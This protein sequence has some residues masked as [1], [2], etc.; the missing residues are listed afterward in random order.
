MFDLVTGVRVAAVAL[1]L[2]ELLLVLPRASRRSEALWFALF[3][4]ALAALSAVVGSRR[5]LRERRRP[6]AEGERHAVGGGYLSRRRR[7][8]CRP[9]V[10]A[11]AGGVAVAGWSSNLAMTGIAAVGG[12]LGLPD[13]PPVR[14]GALAQGGGR[15]LPVLHRRG[16]G[17]GGRLRRPGTSRRVASDPG[18]PLR[19]AGAGG[20][21]RLLPHR[22]RL[23]TDTPLVVGPPAPLPAARGAAAA[24][25]L[26]RGRAPHLAELDRQHRPPRSWSRPRLQEHAGAGEAG[27]RV[28]PQW[29]T[30]TWTRCA[31]CNSSCSR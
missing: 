30:T 13:A 14:S 18:H 6:A 4:G 17:G 1:L 31:P 7:R 24:P 27:R 12:T 23:P 29:P 16:A 8:P 15:P 2:P 5:Q 19:R 28:W 25:S 22:G 10:V 11:R 3:L 21:S 20:R 26:G 9:L